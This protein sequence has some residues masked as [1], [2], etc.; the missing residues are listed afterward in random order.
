MNKRIVIKVGEGSL[1][2]GYATTVQIGEENLPPQAETQARL[3]PAPELRVL[4][5]QWQMA[6]RR[7]GGLLSSGY[8][9]EAQDGVTNVSDFSDKAR[10]QQ[11]SQRLRD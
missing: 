10:C 1:Q 6:Y 7:L 11:L 2:T 9:L 3:P 5:Q 8:R 4:Y